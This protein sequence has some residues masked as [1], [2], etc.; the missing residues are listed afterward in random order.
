MKQILIEQIMMIDWTEFLSVLPAS[1]GLCFVLRRKWSLSVGLDKLVGGDLSYRQCR[2]LQFEN[3]TQK[4]QN[5]SNPKRFTSQFLFQ[6]VSVL[7]LSLEE[8]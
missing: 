1:N 8:N 3:V 6:K 7:C 4:W 5:T 2:D